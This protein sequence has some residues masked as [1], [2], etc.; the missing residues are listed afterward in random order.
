MHD[1]SHSSQHDHDHDHDDE[2]RCVPHSNAAAVRSYH[3]HGVRFL[4]PA[5]WTIS[6]QSS[7]EE[8]TISLQSDGTSFWTLMLFHQ[9]PELDDVLNTVVDAFEQDY[10]DVDV[11]ST[12]ESL[13]GLPALGRDLDFVCYDLVNSASVRALQT[14][15]LTLMVLYQGTDHELKETRDQLQSISASLV[16]DNDD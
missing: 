4:F 2:G 12:V 6:E 7:E 3:K 14:S 16:C 8:T 5:D 1:H 13:G 10:D 11:I 15:D 9:R